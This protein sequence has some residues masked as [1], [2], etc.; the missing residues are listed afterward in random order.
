MFGYIAKKKHD[1]VVAE[2]KMRTAADEQ[3]LR[4]LEQ[5]RDEAKRMERAMTT[6]AEHFKAERN[7]WRDEANALRPDAEKYRAKLARDRKRD[8]RAKAAA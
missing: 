3:L 8:R 5:E 6:T 4:K 1:A 2:L 7:T